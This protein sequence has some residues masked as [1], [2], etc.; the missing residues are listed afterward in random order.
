[1]KVGDKWLSLN[2]LRAFEATGRHLNMSRAAEELSITQSAVSHQIRQLE[3]TLDIELFFRAS[4]T[5]R[6]TPAGSKL[7]A[8]VQRSFD[9]I[10]STILNV[11]DDLL[12][13]D[14]YVASVPGFTYLWLAKRLPEFLE[15]YPGL[16]LRRSALPADGHDLSVNVDVAIAH[17]V[18]QFPGRR[19]ELLSEIGFYP[20]CVPEIIPSG[21]ELEPADLKNHTLIHEDDGAAWANWFAAF[22]VEL[23][24]ANRDIYVGSEPIALSLAAM[25]VGFALNQLKFGLEIQEGSNLVRP[26]GESIVSHERYY[27]I[28]HPKEQ[29]SAAAHEFE[30]WIRAEVDASLPFPEGQSEVRI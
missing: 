29:M 21:R 16:T 28:T 10:A 4:R 22:G 25:G 17:G 20:I 23:G 15:R 6:L 24:P 8:T 7:L 18:Y 3:R 26:F 12:H 11:N 9:D 5:L 2:A 27:L 30:N 1:M 19:V 14:L 13:G